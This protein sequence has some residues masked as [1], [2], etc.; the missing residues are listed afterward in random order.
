MSKVW[1]QALATMGA[2]MLEGPPLDATRTTRGFCKHFNPD[3]YQSV[4]LMRSLLLH[5]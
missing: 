4:L 2:T 5:L 1:Q 3:F